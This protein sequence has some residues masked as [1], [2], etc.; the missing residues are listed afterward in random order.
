VLDE[1]DQAGKRKVA[2]DLL[3]RDLRRGTY[4]VPQNPGR[5]IDVRVIDRLSQ[6]LAQPGTACLGR[7]SARPATLTS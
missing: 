3:E 1:L 2:V 7:M 5:R 6:G 4:G